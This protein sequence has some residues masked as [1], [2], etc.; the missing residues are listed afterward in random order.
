MYDYSLKLFSKKFRKLG[1][2]KG[3]TIYCHNNIGF[4]GIA[5]ETS[6]KNIICK[7][8]YNAIKSIIGAKGTLIVPTFT[9]SFSNNRNGIK[10]N[11]KEIFQKNTPTKM[12]IFSEWV[13]KHKSSSRSMDP[14]FSCSAIGKNKDLFLNSKTNNSFDENSLFAKLLTNNVKFLNLNFNGYT[15]IHYIERYLNVKYR[16]DKKFNG[17]TF[18]KKKIEIDWYIFVR[19]LKNKNYSDNHY[20]LVKYM[21]ENKLINTIDFGR[22]EISITTAN[23]I[24]ETIKLKL[25]KDPYYLTCYNKEV[26]NF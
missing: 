4:F 17:F 16:F 13:R 22:G 2:K 24:F 9:Y 12:G 26:M 11:N 6:S 19:Y 1:I 14:F 3:D 18:D 23:K 5:K 20:P 21:K 10:F 15:F 25:K 8:I 7:R